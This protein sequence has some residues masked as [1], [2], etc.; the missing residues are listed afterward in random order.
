MSLNSSSVRA[1]KIGGQPPQLGIAGVGPYVSMTQ[2]S[3]EALTRAGLL[4]G[5]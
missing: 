2:L 4:L 1:A 5:L 3:W